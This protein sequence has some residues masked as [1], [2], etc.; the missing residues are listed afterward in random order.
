MDRRC[1]S[2]EPEHRLNV[3][4]AI[5]SRWDFTDFADRRFRETPFD[6]V[7]HFS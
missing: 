2:P 5:V 1:A 6:T 7:T 4:T 3:Y